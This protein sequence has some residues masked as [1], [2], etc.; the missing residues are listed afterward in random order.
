MRSDAAGTLR[1]QG[2]NSYVPPGEG[3]L[4]NRETVTVPSIT[5]LTR[6]E[7]PQT[8]WPDMLP[9][10]AARALGDAPKIRRLAEVRPRI[11][12]LSGLAAGETWAQ[13][14]LFDA[15]CPD[16]QRVLQWVMGIDDELQDLVQEVFVRAFDATRRPSDPALL[17]SWLV[18]IAV[19]TARDCIR[20]RRRRAWFRALVGRAPTERRDTV[21]DDTGC[22]EVKATRGILENLKADDRIVFTLRFMA[23]LE[24]GEIADTCGI[25]VATAKR[26]LRRARTRF[27]LLSSRHPVLRERLAG[28]AT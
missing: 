27:E 20:K 26:R 21:I 25:S 16:V 4:L 28:G 22:D 18:S 13:A 8:L 1:F 11:D 12:L 17:K 14:E 24:L 10:S 19:F 6:A 23:G 9:R 7:G 5:F 3:K 15:Y 2:W